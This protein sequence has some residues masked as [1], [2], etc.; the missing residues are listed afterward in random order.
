[1]N[2]PRVA[3]LK[4]VEQF[5]QRLRELQIELPVDERILDGRSSPLGQPMRVGP[6]VVGNRFCIHPMEGWDATAGGGPTDLT[7]RRWR[8]FGRSGAKMIWGASST[9][10]LA[11]RGWLGA[12]AFS[13]STSSI[14]TGTW[15]TNFFPPTT[16]A[17]TSA[18]VSRIARGSSARSSP[19]FAP[20][21]PV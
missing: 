3:S 18:A 7:L 20:N 2:Y 10:S 14:A 4:T 9:A 13:S 6:F 17:A 21:A 12:S 19:A 8:R 15:G 5:R 16:V 11:R 1:M